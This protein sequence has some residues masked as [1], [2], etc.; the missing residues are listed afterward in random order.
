MILNRN[1]V[2]SPRR[3]SGDKTRIFFLLLAFIPNHDS[4]RCFRSQP[5]VLE[6]A[7]AEKGKKVRIECKWT[8]L[9]L[10]RLKKHFFFLFVWERNFS[11]FLSRDDSK[12]LF[13]QVPFA[14]LFIPWRVFWFVRL[15][16]AFHLAWLPV[17]EGDKNGG[18]NKGIPPSS[19]PSYPAAVFVLYYTGNQHTSYETQWP[20]Y[21]RYGG[22]RVGREKRSL[23]PSLPSFP[24]PDSIVKAIT[25][26]WCRVSWGE[27]ARGGDGIPFSAWRVFA[28][29][30][31]QHFAYFY[32][33]LANGFKF[34]QRKAFL[35][36]SLAV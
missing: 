33:F 18:I 29:T 22:G 31:N 9:R 2:T 25:I 34:I 15:E 16:K 32:Q 8:L 7:A 21:G 10:R 28:P 26:F 24:H 11:F 6:T 35:K 19:K 20:V 4:V 36:K 14:P 5:K 30:Q 3:D 17:R 1:F 12:N 13:P 23:S 27:R